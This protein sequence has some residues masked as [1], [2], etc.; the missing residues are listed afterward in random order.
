MLTHTQ[1]QT[2]IYSHA[3]TIAH[4][5]LGSIKTIFA[6]GAQQKIVQL[7]DEDLKA[8][9]K[10]GNKKSLIY[11]VL[12]SSQYFFVL[13]GTALAFW[14]GFRMFQ[15]GQIPNVGTVF[16]VVLSVTLGATSVISFMPSIL[17]ITNAISSAIELFS[18]MDK[19]SS[20]DPLSPEGK[21]PATC[22]GEIEFRNVQFAYPSRPTA[23]VLHD[24]NLSIPAG[25]TTALVGPSGCGKSTVVGLLERWYQPKS[26]LILADGHDI[27]DLNTNWLRSNIRLVQQEPTL[28]S[29]TVFQNVV[30]GLVGDQQILSEQSQMQLVEEAC[31]AADAHDFI[32]RLPER[33]HTQLGER[34]GMLSGGQLQ[35]ISIAR[36]IISDPKILLCDEATSALD[37]RA[38]KVVQDALANISAK[39]TTLIIAHKLA[40]V[41][42]ADSIAVMNSGKIVEQGTHS[43]LIEHDGLYAAMV[44]AQDLGAEAGKQDSLSD[45]PEEQDTQKEDRHNLQ[46]QRTQSEATIKTQQDTVAYLSAGTLGYPL[47]KCIIIMLKENR[48]L[49]PWYLLISASYIMVGGTYPAQAVLFSRIINVFTLEPAEGKRQADFYALMFFVLALMNLVGY[50]CVGISTNM[51]GQTMTHRYRREMLERM[52]S[53]DL[54]FFDCPDNSSG[55]LTA[56]LSSVPSAVQELMSGNLGLLL[57]VIVNVISTSALGIAFGWKLGLTIVFGGLTVIVGS[58]FIRVRLDQKLEART[59]KQF[60]KSASLASEAVGAIRTVSLLTLESSVLNEYGQTL[61]DI[62]SDVVRSLVSLKT[63]LWEN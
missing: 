42:A 31:K 27:S 63:R 22:T 54:D 39:R 5:A 51:I 59:E 57:T 52:M 17:T 46:L 14:Q 33:Y 1:I 58:G 43:E 50:F 15:S 19:P 16:T 24:L 8:A 4:D 10:E 11:G 45:E 48:A 34:G 26:G 32:S 30:K 62:V 53:F 56:K 20:L 36:S 23:T 40:T 2:R 25:K 9:H 35:R 3:A 47:L 7:Y 41:M 38:E 61:D 12:F 28:F 37:P 55:A 60:S 18:I 21:R 6:F 13:S 44:R 29:G 49:Y